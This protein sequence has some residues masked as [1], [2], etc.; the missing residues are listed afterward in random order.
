MLEMRG[1]IFEPRFTLTLVSYG[2]IY[3]HFTFSAPL[4]HGAGESGLVKD[5]RSR[6]VETAQFNV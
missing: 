6:F 5:Q 4:A 3:F 2:H 1:E